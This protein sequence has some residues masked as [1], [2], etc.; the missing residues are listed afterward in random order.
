MWF[1]VFAATGEFFYHS[2]FKTPP[3]LSYFI[4]TP[5]DALA[6]SRTRRP[7]WHNF[8]DL[9]IW[10]RLF[11]TYRDSDAFAGQC[12]FPNHNER[13]LSRMLL[14]QDVYDRKP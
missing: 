9:P 10:D 1:N 4:Q 14:F 2:N 6:A 11:G 13:H 5:G 8:G 7:C 3:W 12:G